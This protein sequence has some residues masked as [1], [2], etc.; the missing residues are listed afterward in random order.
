MDLLDFEPTDMYFAEPLDPVAEALIN[1]AAELYGQ[2]D[3]E[4]KLRAAESIQPRH[5][6]VLVALYRYHF[7]RHEHARAL[8]VAERAMGVTARRLEF[9]EQ[10][11]DVGETDV[12]RATRMQPERTRF[13]LHALKGA[14]Y[15]HLRL[16]NHEEGLARL[17]HVASLDA[18]DRLGAK[19]LADVV[20][21]S[22]FADA[23]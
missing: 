3:A 15:L 2:P 14:G 21:Q 16:G 22:L 19:A 13:F 18:M 20:R 6:S 10:W 17:D 7:Y 4:A 8:A 23:A 9:P 1:E 12:R 5:P 11:R